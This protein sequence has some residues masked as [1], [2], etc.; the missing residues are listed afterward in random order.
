MTDKQDLKNSPQEDIFSN[1]KYICDSTSLIVDAL[2]RGLDIAQLP[3]GDIIVTEIKTVNTL[4]TWDK[5]KNKMIKIG[6]N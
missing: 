6:H 1:I 3:S 4:Y 2:Q 5:E